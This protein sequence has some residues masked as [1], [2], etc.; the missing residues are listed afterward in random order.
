MPRW[1][2]APPV[3]LPSTVVAFVSGGVPVVYALLA[4]TVDSYSGK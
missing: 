2:R 1:W 3:G 4:P